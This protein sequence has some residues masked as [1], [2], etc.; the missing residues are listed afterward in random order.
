M[1]RFLIPICVLLIMLVGCQT[2]FSPKPSPTLTP[3]PSITPINT[4]ASTSTVTLTPS[5]T[6]T[7]SK[8]KPAECQFEAPFTMDMQ[9]GF[10]TVPEDRSRE[11]SP[12]IQLHFAIVHSENPNPAP[13]PIVILHGGPGGYTLD[14]LHYW[15]SI[16]G[17]P[18]LDRDLII[19]DQRGIG[20]STPSLNC[21]E[22]QDQW[23]QDWTKDL[24]MQEADQNYNRALKACYDRLLGEGIN[25]STYTTAANATDLEDLRLTLGYSEWNLYG[26]SYGTR[27]ALTSMRDHPA[28]LRSVI[29]DS[30]FPP[31]ADLY[32]SIPADMERSLELVFSSCAS[33]PAC[34]QAYPDL[35]AAFYKL[36]TQL[37]AQP[38]AF[39]LYRSST[40]SFYNMLLNGDRFIWAV[41]QLLF[42][43]DQIRLLPWH[44][45]SFLQGETARFTEVLTWSIVSDDSW[46][47][48]MYYSIQCNEEEPFSSQE[49]LES[50]NMNVTARLVEAFNPGQIYQICSDW[51]TT[52]APSLESEAVTSD[53]PTLILSGEFDPI[54]PPD[55]ARST[56]ETLS[57]YQ[58]FVFPGFGHGVLGS[59]ADGGACALEIASRFLAYPTAPVDASCIDSLQ[60]EFRTG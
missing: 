7:P 37:D 52:P 10:L 32:S 30:V 48:G 18:H 54:T 25:P 14:M 58:L 24:S 45:Y 29:L 3:T 43:T 46:S 50:A 31:Q 13:D 27:L 56:A 38:K 11:N 47:E 6:S 59:G 4:L 39:K 9:C 26:S 33:D 44:I 42:M 22:A 21:P 53:I 16:F 51:E 5:F 60:L 57:K 23:F 49:M 28:G 12:E 35:E 34:H 36:V 40:H 55:W 8:F 20:Y 19:L 15:L 2:A 1:K 17:Y 41:F